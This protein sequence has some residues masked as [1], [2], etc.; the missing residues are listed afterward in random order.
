MYAMEQ[1]TQN[2]GYPLPMTLLGI[3]PI[4]ALAI[5]HFGYGNKRLAEGRRVSQALKDR[6]QIACVAQ[7]V[8]PSRSR[9]VSKGMLVLPF[10]RL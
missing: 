1:T 4:S 3:H 6:A 10:V 5:L 8:Q 9:L 7:V 2:R